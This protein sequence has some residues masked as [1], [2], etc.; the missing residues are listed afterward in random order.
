MTV[1]LPH[2]LVC[3]WYLLSASKARTQSP[4]MRSLEVGSSMSGV[5]M[6]LLVGIR[7]LALA[8]SLLR[9]RTSSGKV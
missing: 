4:S 6:G 3:A 8:M 5:A 1:L 7:A 2:A 9:I